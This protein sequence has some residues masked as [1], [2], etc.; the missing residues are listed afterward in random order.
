MNTRG[1]RD[2]QSADLNHCNFCRG[3]E[4]ATF[5]RLK[6]GGKCVRCM[7]ACATKLV[8]RIDKLPRTLLVD[9]ANMY[10]CAWILCK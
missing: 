9:M 3:I 4:N 2:A 5:H 1:E 6:V 8:M 10:I 7:H